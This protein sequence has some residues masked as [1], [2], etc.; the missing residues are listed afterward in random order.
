[1]TLIEY[2]KKY[3]E[4]SFLEKE[5][6]EVDNIIFSSLTY[7]NFS[8]IIKKG[9]RYKRKLNDVSKEYFKKYTKKENKKNLSNIRNAIKILKAMEN[10]KRYGDTILYNYCYIGNE[11]QQFSALTIKFLP[12]TLY[13]SFEGTDGL[14]SGWEEDFK[15]TYMFPVEAQK[16][17]IKYL[18][19]YAFTKSNLI[20]GGHSKGG[21][22]ALVASMYCN[23]SIN[24]RIINIYNNDGPGLRNEQIKS[25][26]YKN[27]ENK[28]VHFIPSYSVVGLLLR[29]T[30]KTVIKSSKKIYLAHNPFYWIVNENKLER[31]KLSKFS[32]ILGTS[33]TRWL[34]KYDDKT[35]EL[36]IKTVFDICREHN[37][38]DLIEIKRNRLLLVK[39]FSSLKNSDPLVKEIIKD[40]IVMINRCRDEYSKENAL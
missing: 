11:S 2:I 22:L 12:N 17:A 27:I 4:Y 15:T 16:N 7:I 26:K 33:I 14:L 5:F 38:K 21:N 13:I 9:K 37:I 6:N 39:I 23:K 1:M 24:D 32:Q 25:L 19:E 34:N 10:T 18:N 31:D 3:G 8:N 28:L 29:Y 30:K 35:R 20:I 40:L 36:F